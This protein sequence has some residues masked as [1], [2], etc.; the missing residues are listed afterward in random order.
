MLPDLPKVLPP[1][2]SHL[3]SRSRNWSPASEFAGPSSPIPAST[4]NPKPP[5]GHIRPISSDFAAADGA[6]PVTMLFTLAR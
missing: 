4:G 5:G 6:T 3:R 1:S 2:F